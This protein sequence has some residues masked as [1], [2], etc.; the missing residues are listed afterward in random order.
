MP[1]AILFYNI[2]RFFY[3]R[4]IPFIPKVFQLIIFLLYN[5]KVPPTAKIGKGSFLVCK[6]V[7]V[8]IID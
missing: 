5:S 4:K 8:V 2:S 7:G 3:V 6:G 1:N